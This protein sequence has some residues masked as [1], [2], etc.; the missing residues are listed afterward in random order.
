MNIFQLWWFSFIWLLQLLLHME[1]GTP[2]CCSSFSSLLN[3]LYQLTHSIVTVSC[4]WNSFLYIPLLS[5]FASLLNKRLKSLVAGN[6]KH[7][8]R[9]REREKE[10]REFV[11]F[12][13]YSSVIVSTYL[14]PFLSWI[15]FLVLH[16][17]LGCLP[18]P[19]AQDHLVVCWCRMWEYC[20]FWAP[21][22]T[23]WILVV[24]FVV[25]F[26]CFTILWL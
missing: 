2:A 10:D 5:T 11:S 23:V 22:V 4:F 12:V 21:T 26:C 24:P 7:R 8:E 13:S 1:L 19:Q 3:S 18:H 15:L 16:L 20:F 25:S 14:F 9:E 17:W 6:T